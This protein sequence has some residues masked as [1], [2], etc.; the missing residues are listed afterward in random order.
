MKSTKYLTVNV[1]ETLDNNSKNKLNLAPFIESFSPFGDIKIQMGFQF[2]EGLKS[3]MINSTVLE[4]FLISRAL[5]PYNI[6]FEWYT[7]LIENKT[8]NIKLDIK[9][10]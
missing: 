8:F 9:D 10:V 4:V 5:Q 2:R 3:W 6:S 7:S 1:V